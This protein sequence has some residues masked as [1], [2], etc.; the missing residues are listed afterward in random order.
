MNKLLANIG[1]IA[2][3]VS[4]VLGLPSTPGQPV[5]CGTPNPGS[6]SSNCN[7]CGPTSTVQ[8]L[9]SPQASPSC[10]VKNCGV[11]PGA[12]VNGWICESCQNSNQ[13]SIYG[14]G[15]IFF[16]GSNCVASCPEGTSPDKYHNCVSTVGDMVSCG[17]QASGNFY[18]GGQVSQGGVCV[19]SCSQGY[20]LDVNKICQNFS[21]ASVACGTA[22]TGRGVCVSSCTGGYVSDATNTCQAASGAD[23]NCGTTGNAGGGVC[24][25]SCTGGQVSDATN[26]CQ[27]ASGA[28]EVSVLVLALEAMFLMLLIHVKQL[29]GLIGNTCVVSCSSGQTADANNV[30]QTDANNVQT[31]N[32]SKSSA[33]FL[34]LAYTIL[35]LCVFF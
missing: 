20:V 7:P 1:I 19:S 23:V 25:S 31:A 2:I 32:N 8:N 11:D 24:V 13:V 30:C 18:A 12:N 17:T 28:D 21:G 16:D 5:L 4:S 6:S 9:F 15:N 3:T 22:S 29:V 26:T 33:A 35:L 34:A 27:A 14:V 10:Q